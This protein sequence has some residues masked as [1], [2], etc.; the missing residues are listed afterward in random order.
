MSYLDFDFPHTR[1]FESDLRELIKQVF[2]MNDLVTNFVS[3]N[4]IKYADPIQWNITKSYEKNTVVIDGNSGV[5]YISVRPVPAGVSLTREQYWTKVFDLSIFI[6]K[7]AANFANTYEAEPTT[8]ATQETLEGNWIVWDT[9][10]YKALTNIHP[11]DR[12]VPDGN[13]RKMTVEDF[14]NILKSII[15][16]EIHEREAGDD[17]LEI[18]LNEETELRVEGDSALHTE[19]VNESVA[20]EN[21]DNALADADDALETAINNEATTREQN[22]TTLQ[23]NINNEVQSRIDAINALREEIQTT[24]RYKD[25]YINIKAFGAVGDGNDHPLSEFYSTLSAAR[26]DFPFAQTLAQSIDSAAIQKALNTNKCLYIPGGV[27][28]INT[29][30]IIPQASRQI[31]IGDGSRVTTLKGTLETGNMF[32]FLRDATVGGKILTFTDMSFTGNANI[33]AISY[34]GV[35]A[36]NRRYEDNWLNIY[37]CEFTS[38][39]DGVQLTLCGNCNF[40]HIYGNNLRDV[41][42]LGRAASFIRAFQIFTMDVSCLIWA[43]DPVDDGVSNGIELIEC[44]AIFS[45]NAAFRILGWQGV[46]M[47][48]CSADLSSFQGDNVFIYKCE[49]VSITDCWIAGASA[50]NSIGLRLWESRD[51]YVSGCTVQNCNYGIRIDGLPNFKDNAITITGVAIEGCSNNDV[52]VL[53]TR[54]LILSH[55]SF[56]DNIAVAGTN[57]PVFCANSA[58]SILTENKF[59]HEA[60]SVD[61]AAS[62]VGNNVFIT[63]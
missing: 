57:A 40:E 34:S 12:Y 46:Y 35:I 8:T 29:T 14:Y 21:A 32:S 44:E 4:A 10:L 50:P 2:I 17:A 25:T 52:L 28:C 39:N 22:D 7:G 42:N 45:R 13:I 33:N 26:V 55:N 24:S 31:V 41:L 6:T 61:I 5:A 62:V 56:L 60:Y 18:A 20:R 36:D 23:T 19:I 63:S 11:G 53:N 1:F 54:G 59:F 38:L 27:Y 16:N 9:T 43:D 15:D 51:I 47:I 48:R 49:D 58:W 30:I 3:I 37:N